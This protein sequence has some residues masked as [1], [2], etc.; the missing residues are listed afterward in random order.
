M[1]LLRHTGFGE[2]VSPGETGQAL[3]AFDRMVFNGFTVR[4]ELFRISSPRT[5]TKSNDMGSSYVS[6]RNFTGE[7]TDYCSLGR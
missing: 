5:Q 4:W 2:G 7:P 1:P 6:A 3:K